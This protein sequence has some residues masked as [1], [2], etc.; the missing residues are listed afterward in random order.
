MNMWGLQTDLFDHL[1]EGMREYLDGMTNP[2]KDEFY[3]PVYIDELIG[4]GKV[5][6]R[7]L[8]TDARW[9]GVTY[10]EDAPALRE[11]IARMTAEGQY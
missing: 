2:Q 7:M 6:C 5:A 1:E 11:A 4:R 3:L 10:R 9:Y 8:E